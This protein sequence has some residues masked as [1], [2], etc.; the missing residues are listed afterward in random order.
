M[1]PMILLASALV[2]SLLVAGC[3]SDDNS[4]NAQYTPYDSGTVAVPDAAEGAHAVTV[5]VVGS[6]SVVS[7][8]G[9]QTGSGTFV[10]V[11]GGSP[12]VDCPK[13]C[14]A[15]QGV[16]LY[17]WA[18]KTTVFVGWSVGD[19]GAVISSDPNYTVDPSTGSPLIATFATLPDASG[20]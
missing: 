4:N 18:S 11:D 15:P 1:R 20:M 5:Q 7:T 19:A 14:T 10:G 16:G 9:A 6:G 8:D 2:P 3:S 13:N 17:A 12:L